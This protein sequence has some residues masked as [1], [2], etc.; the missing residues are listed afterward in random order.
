M[1]ALKSILDAASLRT[2][3]PLFYGAGHRG[4]ATQHEEDRD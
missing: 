4:E 1:R 3:S 2:G